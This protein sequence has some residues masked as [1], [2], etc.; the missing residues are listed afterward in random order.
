MPNAFQPPTPLNGEDGRIQRYKTILAT[1][2]CRHCGQ[3][4]LGTRGVVFCGH[5]DTGHPIKESE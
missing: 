5:C 4:L 1:W 3:A 2:P